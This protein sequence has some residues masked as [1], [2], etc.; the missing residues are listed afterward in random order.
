MRHID[1]TRTPVSDDVT[2]TRRIS[3]LDHCRGA[4]AWEQ[5]RPVPN[6]D[7]PNNERF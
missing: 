2:K 6:E 1:R 7:R 5:T 4:R 3:T